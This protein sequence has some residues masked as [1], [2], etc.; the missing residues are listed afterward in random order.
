[1]TLDAAWPILRE[2]FGF[3]EFRPGQADII[4]AILQNQHVLGVMPTGAG[5]SLCYQLPA[6]VQGGLTL[7]VSPLVALMDDQVAGLRRAGV[8]AE[9]IHSGCP[10]AD[11]VNAWRRA[12]AGQARLLYLSPE[13]IM[14]PRMLRALAKLP[15]TRIAV[16]EAHCISRWGPAFRPDYEALTRLGEIFPA[17]PIVAFTATADRA[18]R[19]DICERLFNRP[20]R[21]FSLGFNRPNIHLAVRIRARGPQQTVDYVRARSG[22]NGIVYCLS[23]RGT[24]MTTESLRFNGIEARPYHAGLDAQVRLEHQRWFMEQDGGVMVAT[25]AFGMGIDKPDIRYVFH[26]NLPSSIE[27][28]YQELGR[29]GRDGQ[30][31][32]AMMLYG[33]DDIRQRRRFIETSEGEPEFRR[34][35]HQRLNRLIGYCEGVGCRRQTLLEAFDEHLPE[36]CGHCDNCQRP[37]EVVEGLI[38]GQKV[39]SA[40]HRTGQRFGVRHITDILRGQATAKVREWNHDQ[41]PT[42]GVGRDREGAEWQSIVRQLVAGGFLSID[43]SGPGGLTITPRGRRLLAGQEEFAFRSSPARGYARSEPDF[44]DQADPETQALFAELRAVRRALARERGVPAYVIFPDRTL[45]E[46]AMRKPRTPREL[47]AVRGVGQT[48][49][50]EY[51]DLFLAAITRCAT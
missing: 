22:Q 40:V 27:A 3:S 28:Y 6:L 42:F 11:N 47:I 41:L 21:V 7:V 2:V 15:I 48:K 31:A 18:T 49:I 43:I 51:G 46:M 26:A 45:H 9:T 33:L 35:E 13:R 4:E 25:I 5:K 14:Q 29:A 23:R 1:M 17:T 39:L 50:R 38:E 20:P 8:E 32:E 19:Q 44:W 37:P 30:A 10:R 36:P 34:R 24:E 16:D 12:A